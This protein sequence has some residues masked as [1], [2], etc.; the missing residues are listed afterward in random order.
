MN[1]AEKVG[2]KRPKFCSTTVFFVNSEIYSTVRHLQF[3]GG[4]FFG[5]VL[6]LIAQNWLVIFIG[7]PVMIIFYLGILESDKY[8]IEK[9]CDFYKSYV[10]AVPR[11]NFLLGFIRV[12]RHNK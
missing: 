11:S 10:I 5:L 9:F 8:G 7:I 2:A 6:I 12:L 4:I 3:L 1:F